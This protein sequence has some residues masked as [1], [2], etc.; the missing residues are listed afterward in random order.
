MYI[1]NSRIKQ[2]KREKSWSKIALI[3]RGY[4]WTGY[5]YT[6]QLFHN[7]KIIARQFWQLS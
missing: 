7:N 5:Y 2:T 3:D 4:K 1:N 6:M